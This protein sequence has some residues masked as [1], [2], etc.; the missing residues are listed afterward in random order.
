MLSTE[1]QPVHVPQCCLSGPRRCS[2]SPRCGPEGAAGQPAAS[3]CPP[4]GTPP[5]GSSPVGEMLGDIRW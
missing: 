5:L 4:R 1:E 2:C 3:A